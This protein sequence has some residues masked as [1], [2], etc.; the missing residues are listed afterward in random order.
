MPAVASLEDLKSARK[1]GSGIYA[2]LSALPVP[3]SP[4]RRDAGG[5]SLL[6]EDGVALVGRM[7]A[8]PP[9]ERV[10]PFKGWVGATSPA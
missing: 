6:Y 5:C 2:M 4:A 9:W 3:R 7:C 1:E 8:E 10:E